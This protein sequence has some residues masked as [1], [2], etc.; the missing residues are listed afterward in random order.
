MS[1]QIN[2]TVDDGGLL[3]RNQLEVQA[4]R[5]A[6]LEGE[7]RKRVEDLANERRAAQNAAQGLTLDGRPITGSQAARR[8]LQD[9]PAAFR[10]L[11]NY[12]IGGYRLLA[13]SHNLLSIA[14]LNGNATAS[15]TFNA[16]NDEPAFVGYR[17][18]TLLSGEDEASLGTPSQIGSAT[19]YEIVV[20]N[21]ARDLQLFTLP[22]PGSTCIL[23]ARCLSLKVIRKFTQTTTLIVNSFE[24]DEQ[25]QRTPIG[26]CYEFTNETVVDSVTWLISKNAIKEI[27][28]PSGAFEDYY[29]T[30]SETLI[31]GS[32]TQTIAN[33][34]IFPSSIIQTGPSFTNQPLLGYGRV[35]SG[36]PISGGTFQEVYDLQA[37]FDPL[38][39]PFVSRITSATVNPSQNEYTIQSGTI[40]VYF[41]TIEPSTLLY[42]NSFS[43][44]GLLNGSGSTA[45]VFTDLAFPE[46]DISELTLS[47]IKDIYFSGVSLPNATLVLIQNVETG[48]DRYDV[49]PYLT[50]TEP[51]P[52]NPRVNREG[53]VPN[54]V[55]TYVTWD[56]G[57]P[58]YCRQQLLALGFTTED[59]TP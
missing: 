13:S 59:L 22:G 35:F 26:D 6:F 18:R 24:V 2:V 52:L 31:P 1:T 15:K 45:G 34:I 20:N 16:F 42:A 28:V 37:V 50:L 14:T 33:G 55:T 21:V 11:S 57:K 9:E 49:I 46:A 44:I 38:L 27:N 17:N 4:N 53:K 56:W 43:Q 23:H 47:Q 25:L 12:A 58:S 51:D 48:F 39:D 7:N 10:S 30:V 36:A 29:S 32:I 8:L 3:E 54:T 40:P 5:F 41:C 19:R